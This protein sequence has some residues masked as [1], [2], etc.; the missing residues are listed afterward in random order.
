MISFEV[1]PPLTQEF[2]QSVIQEVESAIPAA[3]ISKKLYFRSSFLSLVTYVIDQKRQKENFSMN[4]GK[5]DQ[6]FDPECAN[7]GLVFRKDNIWVKVRV[8]GGHGLAFHQSY[9]ATQM[10]IARIDWKSKTMRKLVKVT[11]QLGPFVTGVKGILKP[12]GTATR[13]VEELQR[14]IKEK[15]ASSAKHA[16]ERYSARLSQT[17]MTAANVL[18]LLPST[19]EDKGR[20]LA[21]GEM[22]SVA[23]QLFHALDTDKSEVLELKEFLV[24]F[25]EYFH[26]DERKMKEYFQIVSDGSTGISKSGFVSLFV[27]FQKKSLEDLSGDQEVSSPNSD[28]EEEET[29]KQPGIE[30]AKAFVTSFYNLAPDTAHRLLG[31]EA[32][33]DRFARMVFEAIDE[34]E[35]GTVD[36]REFERF[37]CGQLG[38]CAQT[39][40]SRFS[41]LTG[42]LSDQINYD[43]F[44][45][46][47]KS[48]ISSI[49]DRE[50][51]PLF[52]SKQVNKWLHMPSVQQLQNLKTSK[53]YLSLANRCLESLHTAGL[54]QAQMQLLDEDL[55][56]ATSVETNEDPA[57]RFQRLAVL[58]DSQLVIPAERYVSVVEAALAEVCI[59]KGDL[60]FVLNEEAEARLIWDDTA[61]VTNRYF[62]IISSFGSCHSRLSRA[63]PIL[64]GIFSSLTQPKDAHELAVLAAQ[65]IERDQTKGLKAYCHEIFGLLA[66]HPENRIAQLLEQEFRLDNLALSVFWMI[67]PYSRR[68]DK[69]TFQLYS[70]ELAEAFG[71]DEEVMLNLFDLFQEEGELGPRELVMILK[72][73]LWARIQ[74]SQ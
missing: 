50:T 44:A 67:Q 48:F 65:E 66:Q 61:A 11:E 71:V 57:E 7:L 12:L 51:M 26:F 3:E 33:F 56:S 18:S 23:E 16:K 40:R 31:I 17:E 60:D 19:A 53:Y 68:H 70:G 9:M 2:L 72:D 6:C 25:C 4:V 28:P 39:C 36:R 8:R 24:L 30:R 43:I 10:G 63:C 20:M 34:D 15:S 47:L 37:F 46:F 14:E 5:F 52:W 21:S 41:S 32:D 35:S 27:E 1:K 64:R 58:V 38:M 55:A 62:H 42:L 73:Q 54:T 74:I 49:I 29:A 13:V 45:V 59:F 22:R 69:N